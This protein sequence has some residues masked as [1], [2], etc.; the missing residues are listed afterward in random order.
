MSSYLTQKAAKKLLKFCVFFLA[1][2]IFSGQALKAQD[3]LPVISGESWQKRSEFINAALGYL[4]TP[5]ASGG[6]TERGMD[7]SGLIWRAGL[8]G[9]GISFPRTAL[10]LSQYAQRIDESELEPG[11]LVFFDTTGRISHVGI[12]LGNGDFVHSASD[13][14]TTGV[15]VSNLSE[16]YW[17]RTYRFSGRI[18]PSAEAENNAVPN[19]AVPE[20]EKQQEATGEPESALSG[21]DSL[22]GQT[23]KSGFRLELRGTALW[24][25]EYEEKFIRGMTISATAQWRGQLTYYPGFTAGFSWDTRH[26]TMSVPLYFSLTAQNGLGFFV[27]TQFIFYSGKEG[28]TETFFPGIIGA[29]WTSPS[30]ELGPVKLSFYQSI[31][32]VFVRKEGIAGRMLSDVFRLSTGVT[33]AIG[34]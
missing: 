10:S 28:S 12:Y 18:F 9:P 30:K 33:F 29:S 19:I 4:G 25:F 1:A 3:S 7:C 5:Y 15:I 11:D 8:E 6:T 2:L 26:G 32:C 20:V 14:P 16:S 13:G 17:S 22:R 31:E 21:S 27:G 24:D 34:N 23:D